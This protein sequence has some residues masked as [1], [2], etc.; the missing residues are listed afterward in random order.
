[1]RLLVIRRLLLVPEVP[2]STIVRDMED[3][4]GDDGEMMSCDCFCHTSSLCF[5]GLSSWEVEKAC[6]ADDTD[7][8]RFSAVG[9][10]E[11]CYHVMTGLC[12]VC[13]ILGP[14]DALIVGWRGQ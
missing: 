7:L 11:T 10:G 9:L 12:L 3:G 13:L 8:W 5:G 1:M 14:H 6:A 2:L 4:C